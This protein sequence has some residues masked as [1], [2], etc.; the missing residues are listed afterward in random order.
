MIELF[1]LNSSY[2]LE[3]YNE[4]IFL[5]DCFANL[6]KLKYNK[7]EGDHDGRKRIKGYSVLKFICLNY[8]INSPLA[9]RNDDDRLEKSKQLAGIDWNIDSDDIAQEVITYYIEEIQGKILSIKALDTCKGLYHKLLK[10]IDEVDFS[11]TLASGA[12]KYD[13]SKYIK[14]PKELEQMHKN[15]KGFEDAVL[16]DLRGKTKARGGRKISLFEE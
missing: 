7:K 1:G 10:H 5:I 8:K 16:E 15:M 6:M 2:E 13:F 12:L 14:A 3:I 9:D 11:E 4:D